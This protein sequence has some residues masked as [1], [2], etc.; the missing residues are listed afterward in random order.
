MVPFWNPNWPAKNL[1][2]K[3]LARS[4]NLWP[5]PTK[6]RNTS[7]L[8]TYVLHSVNKLCYHLNQS[9]VKYYEEAKH[10]RPMTIWDLWSRLSQQEGKSSLNM[11]YC[12]CLFR[13]ISQCDKTH[14]SCVL[15]AN[16]SWSLTYKLNVI[17]HNFGRDFLRRSPEHINFAINNANEGRSF[18]GSSLNRKI[19]SMHAATA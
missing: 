12:C 2:P 14:E 11:I 1:L 3:N 8:V 9:N 19:L 15:L 16:S 18:F 5:N 10:S 17:H 13:F 4:R 7:R 6:S